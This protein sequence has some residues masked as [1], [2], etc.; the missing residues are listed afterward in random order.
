MEFVDV[1]DLVTAEKLMDGGG[2]AF[3]VVWYG[4]CWLWPEIPSQFVKIVD[5]AQR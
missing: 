5:I 1:I 2:G 3:G 4:L